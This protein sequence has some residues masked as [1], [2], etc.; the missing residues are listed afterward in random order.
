MEDIGRRGGAGGTDGRRRRCRGGVA[1]GGRDAR[2]VEVVRSIAL[3][4]ALRQLHEVAS[5]EQ[6]QIGAFALLLLGVAQHRHALL[7]SGVVVLE[8]GEIRQQLRIIGDKIKGS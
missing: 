1:S 8:Y 3:W 6:I 4:D 2:I 5:G 7:H